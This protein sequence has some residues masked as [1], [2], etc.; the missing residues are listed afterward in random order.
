MLVI[1]L[2]SA[3]R[4]DKNPN[5]ILR[6]STNR[7]PSFVTESKHNMATHPEICSYHN[8]KPPSLE[9]E[10]CPPSDN[11]KHFFQISFFIFFFYIKQGITRHTAAFCSDKQSSRGCKKILL[12]SIKPQRVNLRWKVQR[13]SLWHATPHP[14]CID[15]YPLHLMILALHERL[16][17]QMLTV[18]W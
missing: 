9:D 18:F 16:P 17:P 8:L 1:S 7:L 3:C 11:S 2:M 12:G 10:R 13:S 14:R 4:T 6:R 5:F 15:P